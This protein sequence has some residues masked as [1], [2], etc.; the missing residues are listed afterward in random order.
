M[1][2]GD[3]LHAQRMRLAVAVVFRQ[4]GSRIA[5]QQV[6]VG[7]QRG[8][9]GAG[10]EPG[11]D[12]L[13]A[14]MRA[15]LQHD[16]DGIDQEELVLQL[17]IALHLFFDGAQQIFAALE[18]IAAD[19]RQIIF[20]VLGLFNEARHPAIWLTSAT[21]K[22]RGSGTALTQATPSLFSRSR[23]EKSV[24]IKVSEKHMIIGPA[25]YCR[26]R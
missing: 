4:H 22:R 21:P 7:L 5:F 6:A 2:T 9:D 26:A 23:N 3:D 15:A 11:L 17:D 14:D 12:L 10:V 13:D 8:A 20:H 25:R 1:K 16:V 24:S 19:Q 18:I